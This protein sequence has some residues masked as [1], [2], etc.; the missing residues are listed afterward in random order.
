MTMTEKIVKFDLRELRKMYI[1]RYE[2]GSPF[3]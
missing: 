3:L 1:H 2:V